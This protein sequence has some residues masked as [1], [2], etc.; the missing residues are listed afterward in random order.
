MPLWFLSV[1]DC[2]Y[3]P[4]MGQTGLTLAELADLLRPA[5][6]RQAAI[7]PGPGA[8]DAPVRVPAF[9]QAREARALLRRRDIASKY[10]LCAG[11]L[12]GWRWQM[13]SALSA[14]GDG[15]DVGGDGDVE[16]YKP[17]RRTPRGVLSPA[18]QPG[19]RA[20]RRGRR[21]VRRVRPLLPDHETA[22]PASDRSCF[23]AAGRHTGQF[24][25]AR[26]PGDPGLLS[27]AP[28]DS[29]RYDGPRCA[30]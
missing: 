10:M 20:A 18:G 4:P 22:F 29:A 5:G 6:A 26:G 11:S 25:A 19:Q 2:G 8:G 30:G 13:A 27:P 16:A 15:G 7:P 24:A 23:L 28:R 14:I 3:A 12:V 1:S 9:R 17:S 21:R